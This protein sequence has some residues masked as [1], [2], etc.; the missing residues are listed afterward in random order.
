VEAICLLP[1]H[2]HFIMHLPEGDADFSTR[3]SAIKARFTHEYLRSGGI[4]MGKKLVR[5]D[6]GEKAI[7]QRRFWEHM[8]RDEDDFRRHVDYIHFNPVKHGLVINVR[9]WPWSSFHRY[10]KRGLYPIDWSN[11]FSIKDGSAFGE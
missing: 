11:H 5:R 4:E 8:I 7:W 10:V 1:E 6:K 3:I 9:D 2:L